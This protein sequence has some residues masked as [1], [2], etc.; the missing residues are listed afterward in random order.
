MSRLSPSKEAIRITRLWREYGPGTY[1][2]IMADVVEHLIRPTLCNENLKLVFSEFDSFDGMMHSE[3]G[4]NWVALVNARISSPGRRNFTA[5][6]EIFHFLA[7]RRIATAF[8]CG[9]RELSDFDRENLEVEANAFASQLLLP[10]D[11][12]RKRFD[13][14]FCYEVVHELATSLGASVAAVAHKWVR[15]SKRRKIAFVKSRDGFM[16]SGYSSDPAFSAGFYVKEGR[17]V[18][19]NSLTSAWQRGAGQSIHS[20]FASGHWHPRLAGVEYVHR[21]TYEDF[22]Y[23]FLEFH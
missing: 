18:P 3:D 2:I 16:S 12:L 4:E 7:H 11:L 10:P 13:E 19:D 6:H 14:P 8:R 23:T 5:A 21:T 9:E 1:P 22:T 20:D 15:M 17:E